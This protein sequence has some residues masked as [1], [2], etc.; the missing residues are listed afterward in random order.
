MEPARLVGS[1]VQE[2]ITSRGWKG[3]VEGPAAVAVP[4]ER[5][6]ARLHGIEQIREGAVNDLG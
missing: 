6:L 4:G 5:L 1:V 2:A 3:G